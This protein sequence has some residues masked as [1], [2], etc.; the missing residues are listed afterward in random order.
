[1]RS[2]DGN[3]EYLKIV[4]WYG[5]LEWLPGD[6]NQEYLKFVAR[7]ELHERDRGDANQEYLKFVAR[8][9]LHER[10]RAAEIKHISKSSLEMKCMNSIGR[11][12][13]RI[14]QNRRSK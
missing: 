9:E 5:L 6:A 2:G 8:N 7:N 11:R 1:M 10:D 12:K 3:Q 13:S 14:S 4:A